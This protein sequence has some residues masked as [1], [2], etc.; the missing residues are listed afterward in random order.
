MGKKAAKL[1]APTSNNPEI[2]TVTKG[3]EDAMMSNISGHPSINELPMPP[4]DSSS[5]L[6]TNE[7]SSRTRGIEAK[8]TANNKKEAVINKSKEVLNKTKQFVKSGKI[9]DFTFGYLNIAIICVVLVG[10][11]LLVYYFYPVMGSFILQII[12]IIHFH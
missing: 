7:P 5:G 11:V 3:F 1:K 12:T 8:E 4:M 6:E 9:M 2:S 10:L